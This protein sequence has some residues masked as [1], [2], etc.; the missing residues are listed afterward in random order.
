MKLRHGILLLFWMTTGFVGLAQT[1]LPP[2]TTQRLSS[3]DLA[4]MSLEDL[5]KLQNAGLSSELEK[6]LNSLIAV[7]KHPASSP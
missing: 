3:I 2:D 5:L 7:V 6:T 1:D 4:N